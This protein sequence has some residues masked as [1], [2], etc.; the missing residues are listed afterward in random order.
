MSNGPSMRCCHGSRH[1]TCADRCSCSTF[2]YLAILASPSSVDGTPQCRHTSGRIAA[3][4]SWYWLCSIVFDCMGTM[5]TLLDTTPGAPR[6]LPP[7][8]CRNCSR[9]SAIAGSEIFSAVLMMKS[10]RAPFRQNAVAAMSSC[11]ASEI[12]VAQI[13][14]GAMPQMPFSDIHRQWSTSSCRSGDH[15]PLASRNLYEIV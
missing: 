7:Y 2:E 12:D 14:L 1:H 13:S 8:I 3:L 9:S 15:V 10:G 5:S 11:R 4:S 6:L